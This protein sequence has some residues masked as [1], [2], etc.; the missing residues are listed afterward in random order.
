M[1]YECPAVNKFWRIG[2]KMFHGK[3]LRF[4]SG[5][6][7]KGDIVKYLWRMVG[8]LLQILVWNEMKYGFTDFSFL[9]IQEVK[10][11][12]RCLVRGRH[13]YFWDAMPQQFDIILI[14]DI[15]SHLWAL[16][17]TC[18]DKKKTY[19]ISFHSHDEVTPKTN[20]FIIVFSIPSLH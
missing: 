7:N 2:Y 16:L 15:D 3:W 6:K 4:T 14:R 1:R 9:H 18:R 10:T 20:I 19:T 17:C 13:Y 11:L 12:I 5:P 8:S